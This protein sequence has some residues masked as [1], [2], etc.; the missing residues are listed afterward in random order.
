MYAKFL[1]VGLGGSGGKTLRFL[2]RELKRWQA[3]HGIDGPLPQGWQFVN[4]DTPTIPDGAGLDD[5]VEPLPADEYV[6]LSDGAVTFKAVQDA[7]DAKAGHHYEICGWRPDPAGPAGRLDLLNG[8]G[9]YRAV[10]QTVALAYASRISRELLKRG[11]RLAAPGIGPQLGKLFEQV[12]GEAPR[13]SSNV[14]VVVVSSLAGGTGA[15]TARNRLRHTPG[16]RIA[17]RCRAASLRA[18]LHPRRVRRAGR[19]RDGWNPGERARCGL[20]VDERRLAQPE[21]TRYLCPIRYSRTPAS[22]RTRANAG[23]G[24]PIRSLSDARIPTASPSARR[25]RSSR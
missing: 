2:K 19:R 13:P 9:Q 10:G 20:R 4:I 12:T 3:E 25:S 23:A 1:F 5:V 22:S 14:Y 24:Q 18:P 16:K 6:G 7:L 11:G 21:R 15:G 17:R 8:A